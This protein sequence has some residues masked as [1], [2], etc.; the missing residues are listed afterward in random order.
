MEVEV[1]PV[2]PTAKKDKR[3]FR[4]VIEQILRKPI[5]IIIMR[6]KKQEETLMRSLKKWTLKLLLTTGMG[7][8]FFYLEYFSPATPNGEANSKRDKIISMSKGI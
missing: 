2:Q 8:S 7:D 5:A 3:I 1:K 4:E 6:H